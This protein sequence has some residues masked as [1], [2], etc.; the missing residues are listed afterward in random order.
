MRRWLR[1]LSR[2]YE[3]LWDRWFFWLSPGP[4]CHVCHGKG[5][6]SPEDADYEVDKGWKLFMAGYIHAKDTADEVKHD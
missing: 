5:W 2:R 6:I 4:R 3:H 1:G